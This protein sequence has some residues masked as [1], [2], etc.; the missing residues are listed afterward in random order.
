MY[1]GSYMCVGGSTCVQMEARRPPWNHPQKYCLLSLFHSLLLSWISPIKPDS[2]TSDNHRFFHFHLPSLCAQRDLGSHVRNKTVVSC[3]SR[4]NE[5]TFLR[6][7]CGSNSRIAVAS[8][9]M[10]VLARTID[11]GLRL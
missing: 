3:P 4:D 7:D 5:Q 10:S 2:L 9:M 1:V 11:R 8:S 6:R